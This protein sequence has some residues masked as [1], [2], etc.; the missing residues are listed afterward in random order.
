MQGPGKPL[1]DGFTYR[2]VISAAKPQGYG[3]YN[4]VCPTHGASKRLDRWQA[5]VDFF[6]A[7]ANCR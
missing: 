6:A 7:H 5:V 3:E 4:A 2:K 1:P